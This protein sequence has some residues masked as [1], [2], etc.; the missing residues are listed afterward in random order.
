MQTNW[1][2]VK[3][4]DTSDKEFGFCR[5]KM[6]P[7]G[8]VADLESINSIFLVP[9]WMRLWQTFSRQEVFQLL[10][11]IKLTTDFLPDGI[12]SH[13]PNNGVTS[14]TNAIKSPLKT[15]L[16]KYSIPDCWGTVTAVKS[17]KF[18]YSIIPAK[19][20]HPISPISYGINLTECF[21]LSSPCSSF[22]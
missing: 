12:Y 7:V 20:S 17:P 21:V 18:S 15:F 6:K 19:H 8:H 1:W 13:L 2:P 10:C 11:S 4:A 22:F 5:K 14:F 9:G 16:C 3:I